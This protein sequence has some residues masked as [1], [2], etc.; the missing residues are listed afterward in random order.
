MIEK[1]IKDYIEKQKKAFF[2][3]KKTGKTKIATVPQWLV[4]KATI[5]PTS[6]A[7]KAVEYLLVNMAVLE[8]GIHANAI[9]KAWLT[10]PQI[11]Q[12]DELYQLLVL[13]IGALDDFQKLIKGKDFT[14]K[15]SVLRYLTQYDSE[16]SYKTLIECLVAYIASDISLELSSSNIGRYSVSLLKYIEVDPTTSLYLDRVIK[17]LVEHA[18]WSKDRKAVTEFMVALHR[19][20]LNS[21]HT[22][23]KQL[24]KWM[25][26]AKIRYEKPLTVSDGHKKRSMMR[27]YD[28]WWSYAVSEQCVQSPG[29]I[30]HM[31]HILDDLNHLISG[32]HLLLVWIKLGS[33]NGVKALL[34]EAKKRKTVLSLQDGLYSFHLSYDEPN[35]A[36]LDAFFEQCVSD[37]PALKDQYAAIYCALCQFFEDKT[38]LYEAV[39]PNAMSQ[40]KHRVQ[41]HSAEAVEPKA[42]A[43]PRTTASA[44]GGGFFRRAFSAAGTGSALWSRSGSKARYVRST[45]GR[46]SS[47]SSDEGGAHRKSSGGSA[48]PAGSTP[49]KKRKRDKDSLSGFID[50]SDV[51]TTLARKK[52]KQSLY[53]SANP[54]WQRVDKAPSVVFFRGVHGD[55][56][57]KTTDLKAPSL[58]GSG[59]LY[60]SEVEKIRQLSETDATLFQ[61]TYTNNIDGFMRRIQSKDGL[62]D[63]RLQAHPFVSTSLE[64]EP[65]IKYAL[66]Q[67][68]SGASGRDARLPITYGEDGS[69]SHKV[70]G[71]LYVI[72][73][74]VNDFIK[75]GNNWHHVL[76]M[77]ASGAAFDYRIVGESEVAH[78]GTIDQKY[79]AAELTM[80]MPS[81]HA[82]HM[83]ASYQKKFGMN[84]EQYIHW[85][86]MCLA[87]DVDQSLVVDQVM[88]C[89]T[90]SAKDHVNQL[91]SAIVKIRYYP[92]LNSR[93]LSRETQWVTEPKLIALSMARMLHFGHVSRAHISAVVEK[94]ASLDAYTRAY[95]AAIRAG[96]VTGSFIQF[97]WHLSRLCLD[98]SGVGYSQYIAKTWPEIAR[99]LP[100]ISSYPEIANQAKQ[101]L[102]SL[103]CDITDEQL[104]WA[105]DIITT[106][107]PISHLS[108]KQRQVLRLAIEQFM[109]QDDIEVSFLMRCQQL[110]QILV[111]RSVEGASS[112]LA[113]PTVHRVDESQVGAVL[114]MTGVDLSTPPSSRKKRL[115][116]LSEEAEE[117]LPL[118]ALNYAN[119]IERI[120]LG[121]VVYVQKY[122]ASI[123]Q[124]E[125][126]LI[127]SKEASDQIARQ[128]TPY[129]VGKSVA[130]LSDYDQVN[131]LH[132]AAGWHDVAAVSKHHEPILTLLMQ[133][134]LC[135]HQY[136][137][138]AILPNG[139]RLLHML[140]ING[141][142]NT[143]KSVLGRYAQLNATYQD[144]LGNT[145]IHLAASKGD[146]ASVIALSKVSD[147]ALKNKAGAFPVDCA[148]TAEHQEV[149]NYLDRLH[150][151]AGC[152]HRVLLAGS[153]MVGK[154]ISVD[155][156]HLEGALDAIITADLPDQKLA[157]AA[158]CTN[159]RAPVKPW[160]A[161]NYEKNISFLACQANKRRLVRRLM[162]VGVDINA[163]PHRY[164]R[165][166]F[167]LGRP[168]FVAVKR[169]Y[170]K[171]VKQMLG[172][173]FYLLFATSG[174]F[175][176]S[177]ALQQ[178]ADIIKH[179]ER[180]KNLEM[181]Q[182]CLASYRDNK[183]DYKPLHPELRSRFEL[184]K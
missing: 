98:N 20:L 99:V 100:I 170:V 101:Y 86:R 116:T 47:A 18:H 75:V 69:V 64:V 11:K 103:Y 113:L 163:T 136:S 161:D 160:L 40:P 31:L 27:S 91:V 143:I 184:W 39:A 178:S 72:V 5:A 58:R 78:L 65:A 141:S 48:A 122:L 4:V 88:K 83:P 3:Q 164:S 76:A 23:S 158:Y 131:P 55:R 24:L 34:K 10:S 19:T 157:C 89:V 169:G 165:H 153:G 167:Q 60:A 127:E 26:L 96:Q 6:I 95:L 66:G 182:V 111:Q 119:F 166:S 112:S 56:L 176:E 135:G 139:Q 133:F 93:R 17:A 62:Q 25:S 84:E 42:D 142:S 28:H 2:E 120:K 44:A 1:E 123:Q 45:S 145:A 105:K 138:S 179:V 118:T 68:W 147:F 137:V 79:I 171:L 154:I 38:D 124:E 97:L 110:Q 130:V 52:K 102:Q 106:Q 16:A 92:A 108:L 46:Y 74:S 59:A 7:I 128:L 37:A 51:T 15:L 50:D 156:K 104:A 132:Y 168:F 181:K 13:H 57:P 180:L 173:D 70:V 175:A 115:P 134:K 94:K 172:L 155:T 29:M 150:K 54:L 144:A 159:R 151:F 49:D 63:V 183:S 177:K 114:E 149:V 126:E 21:P 174:E 35:V 71:R 61:Q 8:R 140:A 33:V 146:L 53:L 90:Q 73:G 109:D 81:F 12:R 129:L 152:L 121:D 87:K 77:Y 22:S 162:R 117:R 30:L 82:E 107:Q 148:R 85:K 125:A 43:E 80:E 14:A 32:Q 36:N 41:Q 67:K 9:F